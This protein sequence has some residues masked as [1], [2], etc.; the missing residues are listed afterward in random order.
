L[1]YV[2]ARGAAR[3]DGHRIADIGPQLDRPSQ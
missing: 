1:L 2:S 3:R